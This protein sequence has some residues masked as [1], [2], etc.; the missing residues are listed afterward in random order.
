ML[1]YNYSPFLT[2]CCLGRWPFSLQEGSCLLHATRR[3]SALPFTLAVH[4]QG[5]TM[6]GDEAEEES[7]APAAAAAAAPAVAA[8][9]G[10]DGAG[11]PAAGGVVDA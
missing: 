9:I 11:P 6:S 2:L 5:F 3:S 7:A 1:C 8:E 10:G 4:S